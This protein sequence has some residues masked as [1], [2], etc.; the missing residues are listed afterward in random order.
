MEP[1]VDNWF[2][3]ESHAGTSGRPARWK[4]RPLPWSSLPSDGPTKVPVE[5]FGDEALALS[6]LRGSGGGEQ[7]LLVDPSFRESS[8]PRAQPSPRR[9]LPTRGRGPLRAPRPETQ[10]L[11]AGPGPDSAPVGVQTRHPTPSRRRRRPTRYGTWTPLEAPRQ[12]STKGTIDE[13][14]RPRPFSLGSPGRRRLGPKAPLCPDRGGGRG[15]EPNPA[16]LPTPPVR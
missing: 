6:A 13:V 12:E 15:P 4:A 3:P 14:L 1:R 9:L 2:G 11:H 5:Y 8:T 7:S 16:P 10:C